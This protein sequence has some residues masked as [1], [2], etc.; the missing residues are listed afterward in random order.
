M[1]FTLGFPGSELRVR[2]TIIS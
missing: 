1:T 2:N